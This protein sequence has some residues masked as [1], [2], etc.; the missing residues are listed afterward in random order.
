VQQAQGSPEPRLA[1]AHFYL[2]TQRHDQA[3][4]EFQEALKVDPGNARALAQFA[5]LRLQQGKLDEAEHLCRRLS[6]LPDKRYREAHAMFLLQTRRIDEGLAELEALCKGD[7]KDSAMRSRLVAALVSA[8]RVGDA[9]KKLASALAANPD[10]PEALFQKSALLMRQGRYVETEQNLT[11][12]LRKRPENAKARLALARA[13]GAQGNTGRQ[14]RE[15]EEAL[16]I[17]PALLSG[18]IDL[19]RSLLQ[20]SPQAALDVLDKAPRVQR[21]NL[22]LRIERNWALLALN[23]VEE[24]EVVVAAALSLAR[25]PDVLLQKAIIELQSYKKPSHVRQRICEPS[26][27]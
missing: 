21:G 22:A 19:A 4:S 15:L 24:A 17:E 14:R 18:R 11:T 12:V 2:T 23:R 3:A 27:C 8:G 7:P 10:D 13:L 1:L 6:D 9:E 26:G 16:R 20:T 5:A 25:T